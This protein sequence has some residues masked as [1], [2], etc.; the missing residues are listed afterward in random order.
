MQ[1]KI[2]QET[3]VFKPVTLEI[4]FE[5]EDELELF[6]EIMGCN[7][8]VPSTLYEDDNSKFDQVR[9]LMSKVY[10]CVDDLIRGI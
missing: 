9:D 5:S 6:R 7:L 3:K 1:V 8:S 10:D 2:K 4:T